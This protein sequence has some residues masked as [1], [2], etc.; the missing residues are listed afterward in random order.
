MK[1]QTKEPLKNWLIDDE[2]NPYGAHAVCC[3]VNEKM[4]DKDSE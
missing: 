4:L 1:E 2:E 3:R